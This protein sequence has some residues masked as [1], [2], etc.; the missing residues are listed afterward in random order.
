M[1]DLKKLQLYQHY[2][3]EFHASVAVIFVCG[4]ISLFI[5]NIK[6]LSC[7]YNLSPSIKQSDHGFSIEQVFNKFSTARIHLWLFIMRNI[8]T[9]S[10]DTNFVWFGT[11]F[12]FKISHIYI[13]SRRCPLY[14]SFVHWITSVDREQIISTNQDQ[15]SLAILHPYIYIYTYIYIYIYIYIIYILIYIYIYIY[16][17]ISIYIYI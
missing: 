15:F 6:L 14:L 10:R 17:Y 12:S 1:F 11:S 13:L 8:F 3:Q 2:E 5:T 16:Q 9:I 4:K 7:K